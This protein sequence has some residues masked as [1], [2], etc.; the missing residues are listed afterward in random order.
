MAARRN[1]SRFADHNFSRWKVL[2]LLSRAEIT[3]TSAAITD[4]I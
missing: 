3:G 2:T 4:N 1:Y